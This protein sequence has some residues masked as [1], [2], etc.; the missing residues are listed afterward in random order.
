MRRVIIAV[1]L[2]A[3]FLCLLKPGWRSFARLD[4]AAAWFSW[5]RCPRCRRR[6]YENG[7]GCY[8]PDCGWREAD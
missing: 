8:G 7:L 5:R 1:L 4:E 2:V 3:L 6:S